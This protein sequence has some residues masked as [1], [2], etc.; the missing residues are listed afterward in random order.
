MNHIT[1]DTKNELTVSSAQHLIN[2]AN[3]LKF[4]FVSNFFCE[5]IFGHIQI[6]VISISDPE[7]P[8]APAKHL[9]TLVEFSGH[10]LIPEYRH[11]FAS[12]RGPNWDNAQISAHGQ[13]LRM[14]PSQTKQLFGTS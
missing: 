11:V 8:S 9:F 7:S 3:D 1:L 10:P 4:S 2:L 14:I 13:N 5:E 6:R 12:Q